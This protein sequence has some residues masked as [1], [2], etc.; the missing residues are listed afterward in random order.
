MKTLKFTLNGKA[1]RAEVEDHELLLATLR[2]RFSLTSVKEGCSI[3]ECGVCTVLIDNEPCYSCLT[4]SSKVDGRDV[5]TIEFLGDEQM[6]H[7]LQETFITHGAVQCGFCTPA[8]LLV[9]YSLL[10]RKEDPSMEEIREAMSGTLCR[11]TGY[12]QI[13]EAIK[14]AAPFLEHSAKK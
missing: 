11:C 1:V 12:T 10:L 9:G 6:L 14:D 2:E 3:G 13:V 5:K 7:P 4:L 8:M